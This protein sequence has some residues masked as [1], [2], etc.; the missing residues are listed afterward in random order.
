[1]STRCDATRCRLKYLESPG[2]DGE[3]EERREPEHVK[4]LQRVREMS[5]EW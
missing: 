2:E 3:E 4:R 5:V 1:M